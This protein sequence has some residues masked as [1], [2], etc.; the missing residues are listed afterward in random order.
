[1]NLK[2]NIAEYIE[3]ERQNALKL[4][5]DG[6]ARLA[7]IQI[8]N[9]AASELYVRSKKKEA[10]KWMI[11]CDVYKIDDNGDPDEIC[12]N[13]INLIYHLNHIIAVNGIIVQLPILLPKEHTQQILDAISP[14]KNVDG[15]AQT[16]DGEFTHFYPCTPLG[17]INFLKWNYS[18]A[19]N[20]IFYRRNVLV[21]GRGKTIGE[22]L[23][24]M[25]LHE[26]YNQLTICA[27]YSDLLNVGLVNVNNDILSKADIIISA[28]PVPEFIDPTCLKPSAIVI[29]AGIANIG[30]NGNYVQ[31]GNLSHNN[32][33]PNEKYCIDYT[34]WTNG[35]GKL[36][37]ATLMSNVRKAY[38][39]QNNIL[40]SLDVGSVEE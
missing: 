12:K 3:T 19:K 21:I 32:L 16:N 35:V 13:V 36:T 30:N 39:I 6:W 2:S 8:G 5:G 9:D 11:G 1:M 24:K 27:S 15:F 20:G 14:K 31:V 10:S 33:D 40:N 38:R 29:D 18:A 22:P 25:L 23:I 28:V 34:P 37:V 7:I 26:P 17:I 4:S